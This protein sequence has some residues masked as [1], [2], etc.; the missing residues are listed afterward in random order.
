MRE[1]LITNDDSINAK[2]ITELANL[3]REFGNVT[4]VAPAAPQSGKSASLTLDFTLNLNK[5]SESSAEGDLGSIR[6]FTLTGTPADCAKMGVNILLNEDKRAD[7]LFSGINHGSNA[8]VASLYSG[9][10]GAAAEGTV[11]GIPSAGFSINT[12]KPNPDFTGTL[13]YTRKIIEMIFEKGI[14]PG[15]YLNVN[16]PNIPCEEIKGIRVAR[17]GKGRWVHEFEERVHPHGHKYYWMVGN[18]LDLEDQCCEKD[19]KCCAIGGDKRIVDDGYVSVVPHRVDN[20]DFE[21]ITRLQ[22]VWGLEL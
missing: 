10:L 5:L 11:Y 1:I 14:A 6:F 2:G 8:S 17:Q 12:H 21:E 15:V 13:F 16:I 3:A 18:F 9:T 20:T 22:N 4:V 7:A 19:K